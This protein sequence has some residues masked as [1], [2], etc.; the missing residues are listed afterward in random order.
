MI[1]SSQGV[2]AGKEAL[3]VGAGVE[4]IASGA[5]PPAWTAALK[6]I[7]SVEIFTSC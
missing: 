2:W 3:E 4:G 1:I 7:P 5:H 6:S